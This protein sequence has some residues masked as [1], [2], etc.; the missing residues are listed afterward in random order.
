MLKP[1]K[2]TKKK[3]TGQMVTVISKK[4]ERRGEQSGGH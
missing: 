2:K 4:V 1:N 3:N